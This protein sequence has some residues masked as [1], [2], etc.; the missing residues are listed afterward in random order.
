MPN[1]RIIDDARTIHSAWCGP[2]Y[3]VGATVGYKGVTRIEPYEENGQMA[4]VTWLQVW[5]S[6]TLAARLNTA[7]IAEIEYA[8]P[9]P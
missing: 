9:T 6:D 1:T 4:A 3:E 7:H 8:E 2:P 5:K